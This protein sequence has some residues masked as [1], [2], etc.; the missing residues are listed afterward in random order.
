MT[1]T[2]PGGTGYDPECTQL[3]LDVLTRFYVLSGDRKV[4]RLDNLLTNQAL[5]GVN[6]KWN[7]LT[8]GTRH[9]EPNRY[10][11]FTTAAMGAGNARRS[12]DEG[13]LDAQMLR[14]V[15]VYRGAMTFTHPNMYRGVDTQLGTL[16]LAGEMSKS[17]RSQLVAAR[18]ENPSSCGQ[19]LIAQPTPNSASAAPATANHGVPRSGTATTTPAATA[20]AG[21]AAPVA[22]AGRLTQRTGTPPHS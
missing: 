9:T 1:E 5:T 2:G 11:P 10:V 17:R 19:A 18:R 7:L 12:N 21:R 16:L 3:A 6:D 20:I 15:D 14:I 4:L 22:I 8:T 13:L